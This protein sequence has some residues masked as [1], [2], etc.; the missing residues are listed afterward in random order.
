MFFPLSFSSFLNKNG[1]TGKT[2][3]FCPRKFLFRPTFAKFQGKKT[4]SQGKKFENFRQNH[5]NEPSFFQNDTSFL[6]KQAQVSKKRPT[7]EHKPPKFA[8]FKA[9]E[10]RVF[11]NNFFLVRISA[12]N[13]GVE[14][15]NKLQIPR[16]YAQ[17][18]L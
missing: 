8:I 7:T 3:L 13:G 16:F 9:A 17:E 18:Y 11:P 10:N 5:A 4:K 1:E 6:R 14:N 12:L 15:V 2:H